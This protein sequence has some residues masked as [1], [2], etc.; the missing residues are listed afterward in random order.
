LFGCLF[1]CLFVRLFV[2]SL[3]F[4]CSHFIE[5][6][7]ESYCEAYSLESRLK[8]TYFL[9]MNLGDAV[10]SIEQYTRRGWETGEDALTR[11]LCRWIDWIPDVNSG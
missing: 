5:K 1:V 8:N 11:S 4:I 10:L 9:D 2:C 7:C 3:H 6:E